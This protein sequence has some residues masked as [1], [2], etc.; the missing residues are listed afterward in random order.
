[1]CKQGLNCQQTGCSLQR[2]RRP[3]QQSK[4]TVNL[5]IF[6]VKIF[7]SVHPATKIKN[8]K[9]INDKILVRNGINIVRVSLLS[10]A[11]KFFAIAAVYTSQRMRIYMIAFHTRALIDVSAQAAAI[12]RVRAVKLIFIAQKYQWHEIFNVSNFSSLQR[13]TKIRCAEN[14]IVQKM[15]YAKIS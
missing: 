2:T 11:Y 3:T 8:T 14:L 6:G 1:M 5:E 15:D 10:L 4:C 7:S 13:T 9:L 12:P